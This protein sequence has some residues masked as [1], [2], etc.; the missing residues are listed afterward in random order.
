M[1]DHYACWLIFVLLLA[2]VYFCLI[3]HQKL[4]KFNHLVKVKFKNT[5]RMLQSDL[6]KNLETGHETFTWTTQDGKT[7]FA[8][9]W[10]AG[11]DARGAILLVH[12][13]GE[14]SSRY[15][16]WAGQLTK[17]GISVLTFDFRGHGQTPGKPGQISDYNKLLSDIQL[18]INEG[19]KCFTHLPLF[20]YGHSMG[21]NLVTNYV[22]TNP[23]HLAGIILTSPWFEL[24]NK[25]PRFKLS[26]AMF[27]SKIM[28]WLIA[29]SD[30]KPE[31]ISR[32]LREV[33]LYKTDKLIH[34]KISLGLF[35]KA[36]KRGLTA[37][38]SIYKI[39][40]P[41]LVMHGTDDQITSCQATR[42][43]TINA[44]EKT[45]FIEWEGCYHELHH[46]MDREKVFYKLLDWLNE[47]IQLFNAKSSD[48]G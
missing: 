1:K 42:D 5:A 40:A 2:F 8:Q 20:L 11:K 18:L 23:I 22:I 28:P 31:H 41:L 37:K 3:S 43:F 16:S 10:D 27:A 46:D 12:G 45:T 9:K 32:E 13:L 7:L 39:N 36:Y 19:E 26:G 38:G 14:H 34:N 25:P 44:S 29:K 47:Q 48:K 17:E 35:R 15:A 4:I 21:G 24:T 33:H 30:I 6:H